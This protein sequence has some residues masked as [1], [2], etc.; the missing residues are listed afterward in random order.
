[1][2]W[3]EHISFTRSS[4]N[5]QLGYFYPRGTVNR[6]AMNTR[7]QVSV[8]RNFEFLRYISFFSLVISPW[9]VG[10]RCLARA[11]CSCS[12]WGLLF[13]VVHGPLTAGASLAG[14]QG[15]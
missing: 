1:M 7:M 5:G 10:L 15:L 3:T 13:I 12:Q 2:V 9:L 11:F 14:E 8:S 6:A 4:T